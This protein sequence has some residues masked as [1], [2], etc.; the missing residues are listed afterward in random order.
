MKNTYKRRWLPLVDVRLQLRFL[1]VVLGYGAL[2]VLVMGG[3]IFFPD[4]MVLADDAADPSAKARAAEF[5]LTMHAR[6]WLPV[7]TVLILIGL[8]FFRSFHRV[9]GPLYRL[10]WAYEKIGAG[11]LSITVRLRKNDLLPLEEQKLNEMI[12][13]LADKVRA[14][15]ESAVQVSTSLAEFEREAATE[16]GQQ[17][18]ENTKAGAL[19]KHRGAVESLTKKISVFSLQ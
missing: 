4:F 9:A 6:L 10:R 8:H 1:I 15:K 13:A 16:T 18:T 12:H 17:E 2:L 19:A 7:F 3:V 5:I 11:D 14:V